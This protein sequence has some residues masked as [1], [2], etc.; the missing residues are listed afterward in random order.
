MC[1]RDRSAER[2]TK[3]RPPAGNLF[4]SIIVQRAFLRFMPHQRIMNAYVADVPGPPVPLY[5]AGAPIRELFPLVPITANLSIGVGALSYAEQFNIT[6]V[7]DRD[8]C[9]DLEVFVDGMRRSLDALAHSV[10]LRAS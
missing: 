3:S 9:T 10:S 8:L 6:V 4:R 5:F 1:I 7:A 2:K